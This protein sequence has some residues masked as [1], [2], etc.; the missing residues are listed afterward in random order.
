MI[1]LWEIRNGQVHG[2]TNKEREQK[3]KFCHLQELK[4]LFAEKDDVYP[5]GFIP[6]K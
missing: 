3:R 6:R 5:E 1:E 2:T 4:T